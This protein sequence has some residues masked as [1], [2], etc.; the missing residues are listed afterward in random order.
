MTPESILA[1][2]AKMLSQIQR[3]SF[4]NQGYLHVEGF[5][6]PD[7]VARLR[8]ATAAI[9]E[10]SRA[11]RESGDKF[12]LAPGHT[13]E[14]PRLLR[15]YRAADHHSEF[16]S[17]AA[18]S[19]IADVAADLLG[20]DVKFREAMINFKWSGGGDAVAWHQDMPF[21]LFTN[22]AVLTVLLA[23]EDVEAD[24]GPL[25]VVPGSHKGEMYDHYGADG[26]WEGR[27]SDKDLETV[28]TGAAVAL[29]GPAGSLSVIDSFTVHGSTR[30]DSDRIRPLLILG[31]VA[32][33][34]FCYTPLSSVSDHTW[35]LVRGR[36]ARHA[37]HAALR[38][39]VPPDWSGGYTS[40]FEDQQDRSRLSKSR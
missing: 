6:A 37:H 16:W 15:L 31:Y 29:T 4:F 34:A 5:L 18:C 2:A 25:Q 13:V 11:A 3:K 32:A 26:S 35:E 8:N 23:I 19:G 39:R 24:M 36:S 22:R 38:L 27:I 14:T 12:V 40:I 9:V 33:D 20:P 1:S 7:A 21:H 30:N 10:E 28:G 17:A